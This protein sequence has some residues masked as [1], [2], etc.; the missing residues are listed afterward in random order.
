MTPSV[1]SLNFEVSSFAYF[2]VRL[3]T[4]NLGN[5][6]VRGSKEAHTH[7]SPYSFRRFSNTLRCFCFFYKAP[8]FI[9]LTFLNVEVF[10]QL[11]KNSFTVY[12]SSGKYSLHC[13][14]V[15]SNY[16]ACSSNAITLRK[17]TEY[18]LNCLLFSV[19]TEKY[20]I[21]PLTK[22]TSAG[23]APQQPNIILAVLTITNYIAQV[24]FPVIWALYVR[25]KLILVGH[26]YLLSQYSSYLRVYQG[27]QFMSRKIAM[28]HIHNKN[29]HK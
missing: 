25:T 3:P 29:F 20:S 16:T 28:K 24:L 21:V 9:K 15:N 23:S 14:L 7:A 5:T 17:R 18:F 13:H 26:I 27:R 1:T 6:L 8:Q 22:P 10:H 19:Q 4:T 12:A 2:R 11:I